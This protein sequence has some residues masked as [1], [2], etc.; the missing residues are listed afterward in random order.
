MRARNGNRLGQ[1]HLQL[2]KEIEDYG[3]VP[4][5]PKLCGVLIECWGVIDQDLTDIGIEIGPLENAQSL[6]ENVHDGLEKLSATAE[7]VGAA[8]QGAPAPH[9]SSTWA[10]PQ[11]G[12]TIYS[13]L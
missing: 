5:Q 13:N 9:K 2:V 1:M 3:K 8:K 10:P 6:A 12:G 7:M 11:A 4:F